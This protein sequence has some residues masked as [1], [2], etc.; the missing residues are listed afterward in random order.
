[1]KEGRQVGLTNEERDA[2]EGLDLGN[3]RGLSEGT[4]GR[5]FTWMPLLLLI[6]VFSLTLYI[7]DTN[8]VNYCN[9]CGY[10]CRC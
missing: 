7:K 4:L 8:F 10:V 2:G 1:M 9:M 6:L 3:A 5:K